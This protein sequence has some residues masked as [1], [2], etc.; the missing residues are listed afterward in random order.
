MQFS[1]RVAELEA[2]KRE[3]ENH[4]QSQSKHY[5]G[6]RE[7]NKERETQ[8][9]G[10]TNESHMVLANSNHPDQDL[11][12]QQ[13]VLISEMDSERVRPFFLF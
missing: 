2:E 11:L 1:D 4:Q 3:R 13:F 6:E 8:Q 9:G 5:N 12:A 10:E 7:E